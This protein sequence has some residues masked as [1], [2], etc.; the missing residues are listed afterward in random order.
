MLPQE[1]VELGAEKHKGVALKEIVLMEKVRPFIA[2]KIIYF[3]EP[4]L[5]ERKEFS[6][7]HI[8]AIPE[9]KFDLTTPQPTNT[10]EEN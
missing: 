3:D 7:E 2:D 5:N 8:P 6:L 10:T 1:I 4:V 9:M